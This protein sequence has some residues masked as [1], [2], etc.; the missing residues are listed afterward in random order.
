MSARACIAT[1]LA[2]VATALAV[3][4][5]NALSPCADLGG[6]VEATTCE[7]HIGTPGHTVDMS[8]PLDHPG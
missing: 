8:V 1:A 2:L 6:T 3:P 7:V 4:V 5:A